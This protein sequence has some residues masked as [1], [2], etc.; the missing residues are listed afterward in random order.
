MATHLRE[1]SE[2]QEFVDLDALPGWIVTFTMGRTSRGAWAVYSLRIAPAFRSNRAAVL[3]EVPGHGITTRLLRQITTQAVASF[4]A[5]AM[6]AD[7]LD[8]PARAAR[9]VVAPKRR[10]RKRNSIEWYSR[11]A[12]RYRELVADDVPNPSARL[13][14]QFGMTDAGMRSALRRMRQPAP[15]GLGLLPPTVQGRAGC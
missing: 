1:V 10:G 8:P 4:A 2:K 15:D 7:T 6:S 13:A 11:V 3:R 9:P 14:K 5:R 12:R